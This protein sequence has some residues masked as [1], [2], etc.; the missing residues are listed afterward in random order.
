MLRGLGAEDEPAGVERDEVAGNV[1]DADDYRRQH[2]RVERPAECGQHR[3]PLGR[4]IA[5]D[6]RARGTYPHAD[7]EQRRQQ[8]TNEQSED[9]DLQRGGVVEPGAHDIWAL[10]AGTVLAGALSGWGGTAS[11]AGVR[12]FVSRTPVLTV[13]A[14]SSADSSPAVRLPSHS[15]LT[16]LWSTRT[17][18]DCRQMGKA[19]ADS[20]VKPTIMPR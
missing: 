8:S 15:L 7:C 9:Q 13:N 3:T 11:G 2:K 18:R 14:G 20:R 5:A 16:F 17:L 19:V 4:G 6:T 10:C 12:P 1:H